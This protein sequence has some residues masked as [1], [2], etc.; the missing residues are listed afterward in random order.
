MPL[1]LA[2]SARVWPDSGPIWS[3]DG[4]TWSSGDPGPYNPN[5]IRAVAFGGGRFVMVGDDGRVS[6]TEDGTNWLSD[7]NLETQQLR[8]V[9]WGRGVFVAVG[10]A[11]WVATSSDGAE[12]WT[13]QQVADQPRWSGVAYADGQFL[14]SGGGSSY[15]SE[16][17]LVWN[18]VNVAHPIPLIGLGRQFFGVRGN[19]LFRS[20]DGGFS[21]TPFHTSQSG[22]GVRNAAVEGWEGGL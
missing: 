15:S 10:E 6:V 16:D 1:D 18:L 3:L 14:I 7:D 4:F 19:E 12:T 13:I 9:A 21:W 17:G 8:A 11:G 2:E 20:T 22:L 5:H